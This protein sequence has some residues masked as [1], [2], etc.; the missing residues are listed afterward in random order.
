MHTL[1]D[2]LALVTAERTDI[3]SLAAL[4]AGIKKQLDDELAGALTPSQQ[5]RVDAIFAQIQAN[6]QA[7][8]DAVKAVDAIGDNITDTTVTSSNTRSNVGDSVVFIAAVAKHPDAP[9]DKSPT[10]LIAFSIDGTQV[11]SAPV[12]AD[13][14]AQFS[15]SALTA[16][17]HQVTA[18]YA[19]DGVFA[20]S[21]SQ[22]LT[23]TVVAVAPAA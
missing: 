10:G 23:Q 15:T 22:S 14:A 17:D 5:M 9:T 19:G 18:T 4:A 16:G 11:G 6:K 20:T 13:G 3:D 12:G 21:T 2:T 1:E 7:V 8:A